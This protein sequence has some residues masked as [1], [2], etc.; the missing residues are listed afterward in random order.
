MITTLGIRK[1]ILYG[2]VSGILLTIM[3]KLIE[4]LTLYKVYT[5]LL[6]VDYIPFINQFAFPEIIEVSFHIIVSIILSVCL[7]ILI[8]YSKITSRKKIIYLCTGFCIFVST[9]LFPTTSFSDRTPDI[10]SLPSLLYWIAG[11]A[12]YGYSLGVLLAGWISKN[13]KTY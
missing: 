11:H 10:T 12:I 5:L 7:Y 3:L 9:A 6:N 13:Q 2:V 4:I 1:S 8:T